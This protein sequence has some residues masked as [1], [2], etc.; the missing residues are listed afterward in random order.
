MFTRRFADKRRYPRDRYGFLDTDEPM[1]RRETSDLLRCA[2][3]EAFSGR[4]A[5]PQAI[6]NACTDALMVARPGAFR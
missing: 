3:W 5:E 4:D 1:T 2:I 6:A